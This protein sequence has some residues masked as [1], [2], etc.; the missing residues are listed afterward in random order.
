MNS[1]LLPDWVV[2]SPRS[3]PDTNLLLLAGGRPALIDSGFV[4]HADQTAAWVR[5]HTA[6]L[7][8]VVNTHWHA[9]HVGGNALLQTAGVRV[10]A[11]AIDAAALSRPDPACCLAEYLDQPVAP[12]VVDESLDDW[13]VL[14]LGNAQWQVVA[15]PGHTPG[16]LSLWQPDER[17]LI[18]GDAVSNYDIGWINLAVDGPDIA[19]TAAQSLQ[20]LADLNPRVLLPAHGP[21]PPDPQA[22]L[23]AG[24]R[25]IR[26]LAQDPAGAVRYGARRI[27]AFSLMIHNGIPVTDVDGYLRNRPWVIDAGRLLHTTPEEFAHGLIDS[28]LTSGAIT[29]RDG[30]LHA[31]ADHSPVPPDIWQIPF[32]AT[33]PAL[34]RAGT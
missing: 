26:R 30:R 23:A 1:E 25:R 31:T 9:D 2:W 28:M 8:L 10:A 7:D 15:S 18:T 32:P 19:V 17:V 22:A 24:L 34:H 27:L 5:S 21:I 6:A 29:I 13:Q 16:H 33:W 3:F 4:G 11:S 20:R 12:Y 14:P